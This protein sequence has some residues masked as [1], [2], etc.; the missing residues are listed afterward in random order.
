[1]G[2]GRLKVGGG[3][4]CGF[5]PAK[6][7]AA[8]RPT[9]VLISIKEYET[10]RGDPWI[11]RVKPRPGHFRLRYQHTAGQLKMAF[12]DG[13][14]NVPGANAAQGLSPNAA[15]TE[16]EFRDHGRV[17]DALVA[18]GTAVSASDRRETLRVLDSLRFGPRW[19]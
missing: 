16:T 4:A 2:T 15:W 19:R 5:Y 12:V 13:V 3:G 14:M 18:I 9:D 17:F 11:R 1:V 8:M 7:M 10:H 6:A